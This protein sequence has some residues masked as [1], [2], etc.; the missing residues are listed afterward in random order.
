[1]LVYTPTPTTHT[2]VSSSVYSLRLN[3]CAWATKPKKHLGLDID[4]LAVFAQA[5][6]DKSVHVG[7][8]YYWMCLVGSMMFLGWWKQRKRSLTASVIDHALYRQTSPTLCNATCYPITWWLG[9]VTISVGRGWW[10]YPSDTLQFPPIF[11][12]LSFSLH[13]RSSDIYRTDATIS[14]HRM[15]TIDYTLYPSHHRSGTTSEASHMTYGPRRYIF[16]S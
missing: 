3:S 12:F 13:H 15:I 11:D 4:S 16:L 10:V 2:C 14:N 8:F 9:S 6:N 1:M 7:H 5:P